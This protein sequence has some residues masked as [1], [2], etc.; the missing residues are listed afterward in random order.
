ME[1]MPVG[2]VTAAA[3][4]IGVSAV[5]AVALAGAGTY[6]GWATVV[7][8][9]SLLSLSIAAATGLL[10]AR[11]RWSRWTAMTIPAAWTVVAIVA[12]AGTAWLVAAATAIAVIALAAGPGTVG[13]LRQRSSADGPPPL[14]V[15]LL[16]SLMAFPALIAAIA[17]EDLSAVGGAA[18]LCSMAAAA[19]YS[20]GG[21][22]GVIALRLLTAVAA[23]LGAV[24]VGWPGLVA[25]AVA[26]GALVS[27]TWSR[28][29]R[30]AAAPVLPATSSG[31]RIPPELAPPEVLD[32]AG[33]DEHG[34][35]K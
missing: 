20:R 26:G 28:S 33:L 11:G 16:L 23:L 7:T 12:D 25:T 15:G 4:V 1:R 19:T 18:A 17:A 10:L 8:V 14:A 34:R 13:W 24:A 29:I 2:P 32:A 3:V 21:A 22:G 27:L 30:D 35:R 31:Y 5:G 6:S 9:T